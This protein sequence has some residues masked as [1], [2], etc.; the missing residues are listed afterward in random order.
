MQRAQGRCIWMYDQ[1]KSLWDKCRDRQDAKRDYAIAARSRPDKA[2]T[3]SFKLDSLRLHNSIKH[4]IMIGS[5]DHTTSIISFQ[6]IEIPFCK[7]HL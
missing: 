4:P 2:I 3:Q 5:F 6:T 1:R 7:I